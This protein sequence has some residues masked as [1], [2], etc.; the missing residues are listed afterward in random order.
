MKRLFW[1]VADSLGVGALP[2]AADFGDR[3]ADTLGSLRRSGHLHVPCLAK[4][5][6]FRCA[7]GV[8]A[9]SA[10][11]GKAAEASRGKDTVTGHWEMCGIIS[12]Q[13]FPTYPDGFPPEVIEPFCR[14]TGRGVL[15]NLPYSGTDVIRDYGETHLRTGDLI[16][17]TSADS[18]FQIAAHTDIVPEQTLYDY[19]RKARNLL[20]GQHAVGRVIARPFCGS[21]PFTRTAGRHDFPLPPPKETVLDAVQRAG[22]DV[23]AIGKIGD[24]FSGIGITRHI[25][26]RG[27]EEGMAAVG[28]VCSENFRGLCYTNLVDFD[29]LYGHRRD[30]RGYAGALNA[31]DA[32]L[33]VFLPR[34]GAGD[35]L[36]LT[37]DHGCDPAFS[38][39]D[40]TRE[41]VP[42]LLWSP[43]FDAKDIGV[44]D[45]FAD[46]GASVARLLG[47]AWQGSGTAFAGTDV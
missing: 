12:P 20:Q 8:G 47:A 33:Q 46:M 32:F 3:G 1:I 37:G 25:P 40:H 10:I 23:I 6:L 44:R 17:Y 5:G 2:D 24:I 30:V 27:N 18:V 13:P 22:L 41:Y 14:A 4:L 35:A 16:V 26:T 43:S 29:M 39:T 36:L 7:D 45:T 11:C 42:I 31:L 34:L 9:F 38:G 19:C 21:F 15:C 28:Q